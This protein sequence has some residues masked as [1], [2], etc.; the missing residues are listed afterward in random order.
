MTSKACMMGRLSGRLRLAVAGAVTLTALTT[1]TSAAMAPP[2]QTSTPQMSR[3]DPGTA[4]SARSGDPTRPRTQFPGFVLD[5]GRYRTI[6][7]AN[8]GAWQFPFDVN[9]RGQITGEYVR[10]GPDGIPDSESGFVRDARGKTTV[11]DVPGAKG[12]EAVKLNNRGQVVGS[13]SQ[14]TPIVNDSASP[15]A[16]LW[17]RGKVTRI[18]VPGAVLT[19]GSGVN[20]RTQVVGSYRNADGRLHGF[21]WDRG[22]FVTID[23]PGAA[24]TS[25]VDINNRGQI[26]G[27]A[28]DP[29]DPANA[30]FFALDRGRFTTIAAP[31]APLTTAVGIN[32][33]GQIVGFTANDLDLTGARGFLLANGVTGRFTPISFPGA[34]RTIASGINNRGQIVGFYENPTFTPTPPA[35]ATPI[36]RMAWPPRR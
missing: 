1:A 20:D 3:P 18:D 24:G 23:A 32:D 7:A 11:F 35:T 26:L 12:T 8:P 19:A 29:A 5:R 21:L 30:R 28:G 17:D 31:G 6:E 2:V 33:R 16:Y 25:L 14:D 27:A 34:P 4:S 13:F 9:D 36:G 22:R 15:H 10:V